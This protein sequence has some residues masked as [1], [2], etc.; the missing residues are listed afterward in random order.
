M[1]ILDL[2]TEMNKKADALKW[3]S[4]NPHMIGWLCWASHSDRKEWLFNGKKMAE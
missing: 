2:N 1:E 4:Y 3:C